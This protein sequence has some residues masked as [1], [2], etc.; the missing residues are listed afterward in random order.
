MRL[1]DVLLAYSE[2]LDGDQAMMRPARGDERTHEELV[3]EFSRSFPE[4]APLDAV[5][6]ADA[7]LWED[8]AKPDEAWMATPG[9]L[10]SD[11]DSCGQVEQDVMTRAAEVLMKIATGEMATGDGTHYQIQAAEALLGSR[12]ELSIGF[13]APVL[14][15]LDTYLTQRFALA[16]QKQQSR[17][18][19]KAAEHLEREA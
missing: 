8:E 14:E 9:A 4:G 6:K 10:H 5:L 13:D 17:A 16:H 15:F 2:W 7:I 18:Q 1:A 19:R 11:D 12:A 3:A